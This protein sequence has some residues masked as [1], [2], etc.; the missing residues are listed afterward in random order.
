MAHSTVHPVSFF[1]RLDLGYMYTQSRYTSFRPNIYCKSNIPGVDYI[2]Q[3]T[4]PSLRDLRE[5]S[6]LYLQ[7]CL[8]LCLRLLAPWMQDLIFSGRC[9][10][11]CL[12]G[13]RRAAVIFRNENQHTNN[14]SRV[15]SRR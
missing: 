5:E 7:V 8:Y 15:K 12:F 6:G 4:S 1:S 13:L 11:C 14:V 10:F 2:W 9:Y 3:Q